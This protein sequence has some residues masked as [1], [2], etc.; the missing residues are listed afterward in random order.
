MRNSDTVQAMTPSTQSAENRASRRA[1]GAAIAA[2]ACAL[3]LSL[4]IAG[5][6]AR[7][8]AGFMA[9]DGAPSIGDPYFPHLGNS[10]YDVESY[11]IELRIDPGRHLV[12]G[13]TSIELTPT[14]ALRTFTF[15]FA[16]FEVTSVEVGGVP[17]RFEREQSKL[18]IEP[19]QPLAK[20]RS[21][22][23]QVD[24]EGKPR[25]LQ[26][27]TGWI[28]FRGGGALFSPQPSGART[29]FPCNDH[30]RDKATFAFDMTTPEGVTAVANGLP[31]SRSAPDRDTERVVWVEPVPFPT[32]AA[33]VAVGNFRLSRETGA[34][35]LP[36][37]NALPPQKAGRLDE[38][39]RRQGEIVSVLEDR[40]GPYPYS[41][42]GAIVTTESQP[43]AMEAASR[44]TYPGVR[45]ALGGKDFEQVVAHEIAHQWLGNVVSIE[46]WQDIWLNEGFST[47]GELLWISHKRG[48]PIG[49]L[50]RRDSDVFGYSKS[51][52]KV[53]PGDPGPRRIFDVS[54]YNRGALTLEAL[55]RTVGDETFNEILRRWVEDYRGENATTEDFVRLSE[56]I[57]GRQ[58]DGF[59]QRWLYEKGLPPLP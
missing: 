11:D 46:S 47:Y 49:K 41:S 40:L 28:W 31:S 16:G 10:G 26:P 43:D 32:Y 20:D 9:V 53:P 17:A 3:L 4:S 27:D 21:T 52:K 8:A 45:W 6:E 15:D 19:D 25:R 44:P 24:Y 30:P 7:P 13:N 51:M 57:S 29:L 48:V 33:V 34:S 14:V 12:R 50:F 38:R 54:V 1:V 59:F 18:R 35:G 55:R 42:I 37:I 23:V 22:V 36:I 58:L 2:L 5:A 56:S 39:L